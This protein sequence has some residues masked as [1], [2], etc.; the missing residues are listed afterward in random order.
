[1]C[2]PTTATYQ[3]IYAYPIW[4]QYYIPHSTYD[5]TP[6]QPTSSNLPSDINY[7]GA[8]NFLDIGDVAYRMSACAGPPM[9]PRWSFKC[10][11]NNDRTINMQDISKV[12]NNFEKYVR[13]GAAAPVHG[14]TVYLTAQPSKQNVSINCN[15]NVTVAISNV[16]SFTGYEIRI[17]YDPGRLEFVT[18]NIT[19]IAEWNTW[20]QYNYWMMIGSLNCTAV[21]A[22]SSP[23]GPFTGDSI[24]VTF[25]FKGTV[26]GNA[27]LDISTST[28]GT[29]LP[30][31]KTP[32]NPTNCQV[33]ITMTGD[34]NADG[35]VDIKDVSYV[36]RRYGMTPSDPMWDSNADINNDD[37]IDIK[38]VSTVARHYGE[39]DP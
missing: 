19:N 1:M 7:D 8:I 3:G 4:K 16:T 27:T 14:G 32:Y 25:T 15:V 18:Y 36:A 34:I 22:W 13:N 35:E 30:M 20:F 21:S 28:L 29:G 37:L 9:S 12:A 5:S 23:G 39:I 24:L 38:D 2:Y 26:K 11:V 31:K 10:D 6:P 17:L 33:R